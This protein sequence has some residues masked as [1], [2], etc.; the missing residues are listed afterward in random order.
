MEFYRC[1]NHPEE[2]AIAQC[3]RCGKPVCEHCYDS[4]TGRCSSRCG[5]MGY[6]SAISDQPKN[7]FLRV[8]V[9]LLAILGGLLVLLLAICGAMIFTY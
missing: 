6:N 1:M 5:E 7:A 2:T 8:V 3:T 9:S 4:E